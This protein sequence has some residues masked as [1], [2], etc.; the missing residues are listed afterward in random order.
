[1]E[2]AQ[3][4][5]YRKENEIAMDRKSV[6]KREIKLRVSCEEVERHNI[7][8]LYVVLATIREFKT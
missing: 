6:P 4:H 1:L 2:D 5:K 3:N 8:T 7:R